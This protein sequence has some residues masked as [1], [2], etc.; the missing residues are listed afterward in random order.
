MPPERHARQTTAPTRAYRFA[1]LVG[2][3]LYG[4]AT[5]AVVF[6]FVGRARRT[7]IIKRWSRGI[8]DILHVR[9]H[10]EGHVPSAHPPTIIVANHVSWLDIW[11]LQAVCPLRLVAKSDIRRWPVIGWLAAR[12]GTIFIERGKRHDTARINRTIMQTLEGGERVGIFPEGTTSDGTEIKPFHASLFQPA[13]GAGARLITAALRYPRRDGSPN[14]DASYT[15][16]RSL[17]ESLRLILRCR[18]LHADLIFGAAIEVSGKTRRELASE[19][20]EAISA[21]LGLPVPGRKSGR[22]FDPRSAAQSA[23]GP[24]GSLYPER[25]SSPKPADPVPTSDRK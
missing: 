1:R 16:D 3:I 6:P 15:D 7:R 13:L 22:S 17:L 14:L 10:I 2:H 8:L 18:T 19:C 20:E 9:V 5:E 12:A 25:K 4:C 23:D 24:K 21:A 11:I